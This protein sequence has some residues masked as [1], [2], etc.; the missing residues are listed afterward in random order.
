MLEGVTSQGI[1]VTP[2]RWKKPALT[3]VGV[4]PVKLVADSDLQN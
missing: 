1:Q 4:T 3:N 2:F